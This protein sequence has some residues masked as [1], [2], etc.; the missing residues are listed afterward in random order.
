MRNWAT[1]LLSDLPEDLRLDLLLVCTELA[2]NAYEHAG[3]PRE[4]R[5]KR[6]DGLIRVEVEDGTPAELPNLGESRISNVRGRGLV[7]VAHIARCWGTRGADHG[8]TVWAE[9]SA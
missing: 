2:S 7:M 6:L 3:T 9:V 1:E 5:V 4:V 8:K